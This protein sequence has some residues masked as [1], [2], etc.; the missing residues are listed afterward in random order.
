VVATCFE[1]GDGE[2]RG[3]EGREGERGVWFG[4]EWA[5]IPETLLSTRFSKLRTNDRWH[6]NNARLNAR[7]AHAHMH[8]CALQYCTCARCVCTYTYCVLKPVTVVKERK[9][10][11]GVGAERG[12]FFFR[13]RFKRV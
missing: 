2:R 12:D 6:F 7:Y 8:A 10:K 4:G 11:K 9:R 1:F 13:V 5:Q 3:E